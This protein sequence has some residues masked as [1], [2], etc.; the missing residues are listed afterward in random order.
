MKPLLNGLKCKELSQNVVKMADAPS[1]C[2]TASLHVRSGTCTDYS[3]PLKHSDGFK[4]D[5]G[6]NTGESKSCRYGQFTV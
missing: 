5:H 1:F 4:Y 3:K 2:H 6:H